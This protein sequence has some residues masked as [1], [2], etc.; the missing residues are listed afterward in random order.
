MGGSTGDDTLLG[1]HGND[2]IEGGAGD[3]LIRADSGSPFQEMAEDDSVDGGGN[4][5]IWLG[6]GRDTVTGGTGADAFIFLPKLS[7]A[8]LFADFEAGRDHLQFAAVTLGFA[9]PV[10]GL[11]PGQMAFGG[12]T[13]AVGQFVLRV[14]NGGGL[15]HQVWDPV[16]TSGGTEVWVLADFTGQV[17]PQAGDILIY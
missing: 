11:E 17:G 16:G 5:Q 15:S 3:D 12:A 2:L 14:E 13:S 9:L 6:F 7:G 1:D 8:H 10:G 4:D